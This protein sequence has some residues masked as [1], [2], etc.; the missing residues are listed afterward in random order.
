MCQFFVHV[1]VSRLCHHTH[2]VA[3]CFEQVHVVELQLSKEE[4]AKR[5]SAANA[6]AAAGLEV[7]DP[8]PE[9]SQSLRGEASFMM[10]QPQLQPDQVGPLIE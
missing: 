5:R 9:A 10:Q 1:C 4:A 8:G 6:A 2:P 3:F 7:A